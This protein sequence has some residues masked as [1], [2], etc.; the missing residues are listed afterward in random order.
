[1]FCSGYY[2]FLLLSSFGQFYFSALFVCSLP[3][4][5]RIFCLNFPSKWIP[6]ALLGEVQSGFP[7]L[8]TVLYFL[9]E[10]RVSVSGNVTYVISGGLVMRSIQ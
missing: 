10:V 8:Q 3:D 9:N 4:L 6:V 5:Y 7:S 2:R 1:M